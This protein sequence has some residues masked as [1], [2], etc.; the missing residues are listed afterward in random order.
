[1]LINGT[2]IATISQLIMIVAVI[3]APISLFSFFMRTRG[4]MKREAKERL[5]TQA[6]INSLM[7]QMTLA[8]MRGGVN[9]GMRQQ[10]SS[11]QKQ[12]AGFENDYMDWQE[13]Y[14]LPGAEM[15]ALGNKKK[16][17]SVLQK[18]G[19]G[20]KQLFVTAACVIVVLFVIGLL[21]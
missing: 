8:M 3:F 10:Q 5:E 18:I 4:E 17:S 19:K 11:D 7:S 20:I 2:S 12:N 14:F 13:N 1:M 16:K 6:S 21:V 15:Y 9:N